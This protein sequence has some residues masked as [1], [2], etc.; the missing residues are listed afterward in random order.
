MV[1][2]LPR[3]FGPLSARLCFLLQFPK[4]LGDLG[5]GLHQQGCGMVLGPVV[6]EDPLLKDLEEGV[7][8]HLAAQ[9]EVPSLSLALDYL[10]VAK[11]VPQPWTCVR[12]N[13]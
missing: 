10:P 7:A 4:F 9:L 12:V 8:D 2:F 1:G 6:G 5:K 11:L 13:W 3:A